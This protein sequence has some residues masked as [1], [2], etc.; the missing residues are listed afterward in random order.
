MRRTLAAAIVALAA[1]V[2]TL[3]A[4]SVASSESER[5]TLAAERFE[6]PVAETLSQA[7]RLVDPQAEEEAAV[8][9]EHA[10]LVMRRLFASLPELEGEERDLAEQILARPSDGALDPRGYGYTTRSVKDCTKTVCLHWVRTTADAPPDDA[11]AQKSLAILNQVYGFEVGKLGYRRP[12]PDAEHGGNSKFDVYLKDLGVGLYGFC[13]PEYYKPGSR[14]VASSYC[15][16]D[17]DFAADQFSGTPL[18]NLKVTLAHEFFHAVQ[19][20]YDIKDDPWIYESTA[21]WMEERFA[22]KVDDNRQY[23]PNG[24]VR[25]PHVPLDTFN[26]SGAHYGNWVW[27]EYLSS[28]FGN[29]IVRTV[30]DRLDA[31]TGRP[32]MYSTEGLRSV[33]K[34][35]GGFTKNFA[36]YAGANTVPSRSYAEGASWPSAAMSGDDQLG[37]GDRRARF[38][39]RVNHMASRNYVVRPDSSMRSGWR[40]RVKVNGPSRASGPA[41]Y[42]IVRTKSGKIDRRAI[43]LSRRGVGKT[44]VPFSASRIRSVII[45]VANTST[46]FTCRRGT[47]YSCHGVPRDDRRRFTIETSA[48]K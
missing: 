5:P 23:L 44:K 20:A 29:R 48:F 32:D 40:L 16:I 24:Q 46:R 39:A 7:Q 19:Y 13:V 37:K 31:N 42:L 4:A 9:A 45:T 10:S 30:W 33:L 25:R 43:P 36:A 15:V 3:P 12:V 2:A 1:A 14:K 21:T 27:W 6:G 11:W 22:D 28:R 47:S 26:D 8:E 18:A 38:L 41:A 34:S 17:N 35:R